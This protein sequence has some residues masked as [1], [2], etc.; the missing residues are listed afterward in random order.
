[1]ADP[2]Q[3]VMREEGL[4]IQDALSSYME[5]REWLRSPPYE[6]LREREAEQEDAQ[7]SEG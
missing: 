7:R 4:L 2:V 1:M 3:Q 5:E 6:R